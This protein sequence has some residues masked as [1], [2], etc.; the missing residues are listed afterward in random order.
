MYSF[1]RTSL[2]VASIALVPTAALAD[3]IMAGDS[4]RFLYSDGTLGGGAF[5]VDNLA[6]GAGED[7]LSFCVQRSEYMDYT[8]TF[9]VGSITGY[10]D[11]AGGADFLSDETR[12]IY[13]NF[14]T[15]TLTGFSSNEVQAAIWTLENEWTQSFG[16][17]AGLITQA[18]AAVVGGANGDGV[19]VLNLFYANGTKA[20][21]Q[22]TLAAVPEPA[23]LALLGLGLFTAIKRRR[24]A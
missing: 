8:S 21:D 22:L 16:N 9:L 5:H 13:K 17:S 10:A 18:H 1:I 6:T 3:T 2:V 20:Q 12:W 11:D 14:R 4:I 24:V 19:R 15:G 23:S 7:F